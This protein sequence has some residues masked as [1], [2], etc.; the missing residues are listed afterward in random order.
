M[1]FFCNKIKNHCL[2]KCITT[3]SHF[4]LRCGSEGRSVKR[5][6][7]A[8]S[9]GHHIPSETMP[10]V[11]LKCYW[12]PL[13]SDAHYISSVHAPPAEEDMWSAT[14]RACKVDMLSSPNTSS[15]KD[16]VRSLAEHTQLLSSGLFP[17]IFQE[18]F[19]NYDSS[20]WNTTAP[21]LQYISIVWS[22]WRGGVN[23]NKT[24]QEE[25][26][27]FNCFLKGH[28]QLILYSFF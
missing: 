20:S 12:R 26:R 9:S 15:W 11:G 10:H 19:L 1:V 23:Y 18:P 5:Q 4:P 2:A 22:Y 6:E 24:Q 17:A 7:E 14:W 25:Q 21:T 16:G 28:L 27:Y 8:V 3:T 13:H